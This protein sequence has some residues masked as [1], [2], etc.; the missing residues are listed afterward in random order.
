MKKQNE[1]NRSQNAENNGE[2]TTSA[3]PAPGK[4]ALPAQPQLKWMDADLLK[5]DVLMETS[6]GKRII[7]ALETKDWKNARKNMY[8]GYAASLLESGWQQDALNKEPQNPKR[9]EVSETKNQERKEDQENTAASGK[10][11]QNCKPQSPSSLLD[12]PLQAWTKNRKFAAYCQEYAAQAMEKFRI[13]GMVSAMSATLLIYFAAG[14]LDGQV[15]VYFSVDALIAVAA[16]VFLIRNLQIKDRLTQN[17]SQA[18]DFRLLD[19]LSLLLCVL[20]KVIIPR[21]FDLSLVVL[22]ITYFIEKKKFA[23]AQKELLSSMNLV[24]R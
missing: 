4:K 24:L 16:G 21:A 10:K 18:K 1:T 6:A 17:W 15:M 9:Q 12:K 7:T 3:L 14:L 19:G 8:A 20:L 23:A 11:K 13:C 5:K 22:V 2:K